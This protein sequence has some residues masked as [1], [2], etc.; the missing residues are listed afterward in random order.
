VR[1]IPIR[2]DGDGEDSRKQTQPQPGSEK[3]GSETSSTQDIVADWDGT[4]T[5]SDGTDS[6]MRD[7][8][9]ARWFARDGVFTV[10][11]IVGLTV[12]STLFFQ[13]GLGKIKRTRTRTARGLRHRVHVDAPVTPRDVTAQKYP[14]GWPSMD[15][16]EEEASVVDTIERRGSAMGD[17]MPLRTPEGDEARDLY[18]VGQ[19]E[20]YEDFKARVDGIGSDSDQYQQYRQGREREEDGYDTLFSDDE[21]PHARMSYREMNERAKKASASA[22]RAAAHAHQASIAA[23]IASE[24]CNEATAA[25][26]RALEASLK[27]QKALERSSGQHVMEIYDAARKAEA[28]AEG[29]ARRAAEMSAKALMEEYNAS[30]A[31]RKAVQAEDASRP[32]G[33]IN[34]CKAWWFELRGA[35]AG[36][37]DV[38]V[39]VGTETIAWSQATCDRAVEA[40]RSL[41][42]ALKDKRAH[43]KPSE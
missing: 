24:A 38:A 34:T 10:A 33:V 5:R 19:R 42:G 35:V 4:V 32:H 25:A 37:R 20:K 11:L 41:V 23:T 2:G 26:H 22:A 12:V 8:S 1:T 14:T 17:R 6:P 16:T 39:R 15:S 28:I 13:V 40:S 21:A 7:A 30:K 9:S 18:M 29:R 31:S 27:T 36:A 43:D 3:T